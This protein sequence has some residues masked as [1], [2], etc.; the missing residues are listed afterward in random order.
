VLEDP[1][2]LAGL[3]QVFDRGLKVR[4]IVDNRK[5]QAL[6]SERTNLANYMLTSG[7]ELHLS[8][9]NF[10]RSFPKVILIDG[11]K[12]VVGSAWHDTTTFQQYR[13]YFIIISNESILRNLSALSENDW[14]YSS[15]PG[16][17][18]PPFNPTPKLTTLPITVGPVDATAR[19]T[20]FIQSAR[21]SLDVTA[22]LLGNTAL[23][24][25]LKC[26]M[27]TI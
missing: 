8:N 21:R 11:R 26:I 4:V 16:S 7:G 24:E 5:Y 17:E 19:L 15:A 27:I 25:L 10:P 6:R 22:E 1:Q 14:Q 13:D 20:S 12:A 3:K 2:I 23:A 18:S 9:A